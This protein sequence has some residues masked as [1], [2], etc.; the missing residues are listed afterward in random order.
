VVIKSPE[1]RDRN[2]ILDMLEGVEVFTDKEVKVALE[3]FDDAVKGR[4]EDNY[5]IFCA[6][7]DHE[8]LAG[9]VCFGSIP[10]TDASYDIY[11]IAV[12]LPYAGLGVGTRLLAAAERAIMKQGG[13]K[14][15][16]ETSS[17]EP[18]KMAREFYRRQGYETVSVL[19]DFYREGDSKITFMKKA[20]SSYGRRDEVA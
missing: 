3:V 10:M 11:W 6:Y 19:K 8:T 5:Q 1:R 4:N 2:K 9:Y 20:G 14:I 15:Y 13:E 7:D 16:I 17:T 12:T 18:Y